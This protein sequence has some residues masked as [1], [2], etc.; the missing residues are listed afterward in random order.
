MANA[1]FVELSGVVS[2]GEEVDPKH[3][4]SKT[5]NKTETTPTTSFAET[6]PQ[7]HGCKL[8]KLFGDP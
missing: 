8:I 2:L 1:G 7:E 4:L 3:P 5:P 6:T